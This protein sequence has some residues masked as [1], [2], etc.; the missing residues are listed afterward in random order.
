MRRI[1]FL[2][3]IFSAAQLLGASVQAA[4]SAAQP[5]VNGY[6]LAPTDGGILLQS[7]RATGPV[8]KRTDCVN[9]NSPTNLVPAAILREALSTRFLILPT[10]KAKPVSQE[11]ALA[12]RKN[13]PED[14]AVALSQAEEFDRKLNTIEQFILSQRGANGLPAVE[15][16]QLKRWLTRIKSELPYYRRFGPATARL[17]RLLSNRLNNILATPFWYISEQV[18]SDQGFYKTLSAFDPTQPEC[19]L[20]NDVEENL[21]HC[22]LNEGHTKKSPSG[23]VWKL[24]SRKRDPLTGRFAEVWLDEAAGL[25]WAD[26]IEK[27]FSYYDAVAFGRGAN[28]SPCLSE[29]GRATLAGLDSLSFELPAK[30]DLETAEANGLRV[31]IPKAE[32]EKIWTKTSRSLISDPAMHFFG[33]YGTFHSYL[34][35]RYASYTVRCVSRISKPQPSL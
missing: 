9:S 7:C 30:S 28:S 5:T 16:T 11:K 14:L 2:I 1:T 31:A 8:S 18:E 34:D 13:R 17:N 35:V 10:D 25:L 24:V 4:K 21:K 12:L 22:S 23:A 27:V 29:A 3:L 26:R 6:I 19:G 33:Y 15:Q 20:T 32:H